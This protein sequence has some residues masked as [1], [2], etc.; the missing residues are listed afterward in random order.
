M[1]GPFI[2]EFRNGRTV[3]TRSCGGEGLSASARARRP[4]LVTAALADA[5]PAA[6]AAA[7][8]PSTGRPPASPASAAPPA[9][10]P[11]MIE[12][13]QAWVS[14]PFPCGAALPAA[15]NSVASAGPR[16][17]PA[18]G[19]ATPSSGAYRLAAASV[20]SP[21]AYPVSSRGRRRDADRGALAPSSRLPATLPADTAASRG[22]DAHSAC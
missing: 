5:I 13:I 6:A 17:T 4:R 21:I 3:H 8:S 14:A 9:A 20:A 7:A 16:H 2:T 19:A 11:F 12:L 18:S 1:E 22:P 10:P 15:E